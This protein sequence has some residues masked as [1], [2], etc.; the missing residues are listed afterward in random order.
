LLDI[1]SGVGRGLATGDRGLGFP[2]SSSNGQRLVFT[3]SS[4]LVGGNADLDTEVFVVDVA[5]G[6]VV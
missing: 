2:V 6:S 5:S 1:D 3:S 4:D